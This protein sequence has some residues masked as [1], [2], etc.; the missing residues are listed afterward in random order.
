MRQPGQQR[1]V[2]PKHL[3]CSWMELHLQ[4]RKREYESPCP[5]RHLQRLDWLSFATLR[6]ISTGQAA[7]ECPWNPVPEGLYDAYEDEDDSYANI[8]G[9]HSGLLSRSNLNWDAR[10]WEALTVTC[11]TGPGKCCIS[12]GSSFIKS[13]ISRQC[14]KAVVTP[15][16]SHNWITVPQVAK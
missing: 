12:V 1:G 7:L 16:G 10:C 11:D 9:T 8:G 4:C 13:A 2:H 5:Q 15:H 6:M 3:S 14:P